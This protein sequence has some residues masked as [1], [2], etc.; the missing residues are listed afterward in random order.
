MGLG[1]GVQGTGQRLQPV[2]AVDVLLAVQAGDEIA[3]RFQVQ[4]RQH[5]RGV[6]PVAI[7]AQHLGHRG[8]RQGNAL[9]GHTFGQQVPPRVFRID[10]VE[11][12]DVID[13][14]AV[15]LFGHVAVEA[16]VARLHMVDRDI[17]APGHDGRDRGIRVAQD[18][19][20]IG[21]FV[22]QDLLRLGQD[23][24][25]G[26]AQTAPPGAQEVVRF[27]HAQILEKDLVQLVI[28]VLARVGD[29]V[30]DMVLQPGH[31]P[32]KPDNLRPCPKDGHH[33]EPGRPGS[34]DGHHLEPGHDGVLGGSQGGG[35]S[36][37]AMDWPWIM[38]FSAIISGKY[39]F[40]FAEILRS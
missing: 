28:P 3:P 39:R 10:Q 6:D 12:G 27:A 38:L 40:V 9:V 33:L 29:D 22:R 37:F 24:P 15:G 1:Q 26:L 32:G 13:Q 5:F 16:A 25:Q 20:G 17:H 14:L 23:G 34:Q 11:V 7:M 31:D 21:F 30:G 4:A 35:F 2:A 8:S 18:Q 19:D 36:R